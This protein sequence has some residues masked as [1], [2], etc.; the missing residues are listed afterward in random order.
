[1]V[2]NTS[3]VSKLGITN[4]QG[5]ILVDNNM[6]T[7]VKGIFAAGDCIEK[8]LRQVVTACSDGAIAGQKSYHYIN[9]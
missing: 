1:M 6:E 3:F 5:Y 4:E 2:P 9:S 8:T 7:K